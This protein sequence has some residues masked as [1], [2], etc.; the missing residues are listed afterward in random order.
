MVAGGVS[1]W[2]DSYTQFS[3]DTYSQ[4]TYVANPVATVTMY[5]GHYHP[6]EYD[7]TA[8]YQNALMWSITGNLAYATTAINIINGWA[9]TLTSYDPTGDITSYDVSLKMSAAAEILRYEPGSGWTS[10]NTTNLTNMLMQ[11]LYPALINSS[12]GMVADDGNQGIG[13]MKGLMAIAIFTENRT[14]YN[15]AIALYEGSGNAISPCPALTFYVD[16]YGSSG[17]SGRDQA[18]PQGGLASYTE[19][20]KMS[21]IQGTDDLWGWGSNR[22]LLGLEYIA[23]YNL[24]NSVNWT[25][26]ATCVF[27]YTAMSTIDRGYFNMMYEMAYQHYVVQK[28]LSM[29]YSTQVLARTRS[30]TGA[31]DDPG[32]GTLLYTL[33]PVPPPVLDGTYGIGAFVSN[34]TLDT[35]GGKTSAST[36][37]EQ[38][39]YTATTTQQWEAVSLGNETYKFYPKGGSFANIIDSGTIPAS[40]GADVVLYTNNGYTNQMWKVAANGPGYVVISRGTILMNMPVTNLFWAITGDSTSSGALLEMEPADAKTD[41]Q[42]SFNRIYPKIQASSYS[43]QSGVQLENSSEG[44]EDVSYVNNGNWTAYNGVNVAGA[45]SIDIR[46]GSQTA[47]GTIEVH[48]G[49]A[50]GTLLGTATVN[51]TSGWQTYGTVTAPISGATGTQ[52]IYLVYKGAGGGFLFNVLWFVF[53]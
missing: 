30:E 10:T 33:N 28:G 39:S 18:H 21:E 41:Q 34:L 26:H 14:L 47:G 7:A 22:L 4:S 11:K 12:G 40:A 32:Y 37:I 49:S 43:S 9:T 25:N 1:P 31:I 16:Q 27:S 24:G 38:D 52:N 15:Q 48:E 36:P 3:L 20:A 42:F 13:S 8:A 29:P 19:A 45:T 2:K 50:T 23:E 44:G 53:K 51:Y 35:S 17:E 6:F 5:E 46:V